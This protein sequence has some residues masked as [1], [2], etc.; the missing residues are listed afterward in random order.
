MFLAGVLL[1]GEKIGPWQWLA[2]RLVALAILIT[3]SR[4]TRK[5]STQMVLP[6]QVERAVRGGL[7]EAADIIGE[8]CDVGVVEACRHRVHHRRLAGAAAEIAQVHANVIFTAA[9]Q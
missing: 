5:L 2:C 4:A 8:I 1:L 3:P 7:L 6:R 9:F